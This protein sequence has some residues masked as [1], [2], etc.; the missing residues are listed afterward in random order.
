MITE[1][2]R[3]TLQSMRDGGTKYHLAFGI[4]E[5]YELIRNRALGMVQSMPK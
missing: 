1:Q 2:Q 4:I 5:T 3:K